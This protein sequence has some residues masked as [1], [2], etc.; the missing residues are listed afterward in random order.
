[1]GGGGEN[2]SEYI[3]GTASAKNFSHNG[4]N[5]YCAVPVARGRTERNGIRIIQR[6]ATSVIDDS[7]PRIAFTQTA[8]IEQ[9]EQPF[10]QPDRRAEYLIDHIM[11][12]LRCSS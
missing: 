1:M 2:G 7:D 4:A 11:Q 5:E 10:N 12:P 8:L 9:N 6:S 3:V